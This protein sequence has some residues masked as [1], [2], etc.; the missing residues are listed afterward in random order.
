[1]KRIYFIFAILAFSFFDASAQTRDEGIAFRNNAIEFLLDNFG[2][3]SAVQL[4][5][6]GTLANGDYTI[7]FWFNARN[8]YRNQKIFDGA[9]GRQ[10]N[11]SSSIISIGITSSGNLIINNNRQPNVSFNNNQ[12]N[13]VAVVKTGTNCIIYFNGVE[14]DR[15]TV[16][17]NSTVISDPIIGGSYN[18]SSYSFLGQCQ[19]FRVWSTARTAQQIQDN[20]RV[21]IPNNSSNL[22]YY[23]PLTQ[24]NIN[25]SQNINDGTA[26]NNVSTA[27]GA[28]SS[29]SN[30]ISN[31][32]AFTR[33][34][35]DNTHQ[36][37]S[38]TLAQPLTDNQIVQYSLDCGNNWTNVDATTGINWVATLPANF[39]SGPINLRIN[40]APN[41]L[42]KDYLVTYNIFEKDSIV[43]YN[44][45]FFQTTTDA[46]GTNG[47]YIQLPN[48]GYLANGD[49]T[50]ETW[51]KVADKNR[52]YQ[53][54]FEAGTGVSNNILSIGFIGTTGQLFI[55]G[56]RAV[57]TV[58][59]INNNQWYHIAM[60]KS[61][62]AI[63]TYLNGVQIDNYSFSN[64]GSNL[65]TCKIG[66]SN[67]NN[68]STI[69][70]FQEFRIW[71]TAKNV[72]EIR[73]N[74][75]TK[76]LRNASNL[77][78]Y[79]PLSRD[80]IV[81]SVNIVNATVLQNASTAA[82]ANQ[83]NAVV[84][85]KN[86]FGARYFHDTSRQ[87]LYGTVYGN[88]PLEY[89]VNN[90]I[91]WTPIDAYLG[92][93]WVTTL[94]S[95]F[96]TGTI[97]VRVPNESCR[98]FKDYT[99][100]ADSFFNT[101]TTRVVNGTISPNKIV[102]LF[103]K[104]QITYSP[105]P[106]YVLDSIFINGVYNAAASSDSLSS[107]T[108]N[109]TFFDSIKVV[110]SNKLRLKTI[111]RVLLKQGDTLI[112]RS[113]P[114]DNITLKKFN[115]N[116]T[117]NYFKKEYFLSNDTNYYFVI[118][119]N[120]PVGTYVL[121]GVNGLNFTTNFFVITIYN[122]DTDSVAIYGWG[123]SDGGQLNV[124]NLRTFV[125][126]AGGEAF[127]AGLQKDGTVLAWGSNANG[128][129][130][131]PATLKDVVQISTGFAHGLAL[132]YDGT[133]EAWGFNNNGQT[134][135]PQLL[136][137]NIVQVEAGEFFSL[138][139]KLDGT[140]IGWG[141]NVPANIN[142]VVQLGAGF[143]NG[144]AITGDS[145]ILSWGD[146]SNGQLTNLPNLRGVVQAK[147]GGSDLSN[148]G[149][150][151][152][153][154]KNDG[155]LVG[156]GINN[157]GQLNMPQNLRNVTQIANG[158][159]HTVALLKDKSV[160]SFGASGYGQLNQPTGI[161]NCQAVFSGCASNFSFAIS[162]L[163]VQSSANNGGRITDTTFV[164]Y[165]DNF[166]VTFTPNVGYIVDSVFINEVYDSIATYDSFAGYTFYNITSNPSIRV[167]FTA[168]TSYN[169]NTT[170]VNGTIDTSR[171][172]GLG[173]NVTIFYQ[174]QIG[175]VIDSVII[176]GV[177]KR[178]D[179]VSSY[180]FT[181]V[182]GDSNLRVVFKI[183]TFKVEAHAGIGGTI[184]PSGTNVA[185]YGSN[186]SFSFTASRDYYID[187]II[188]NSIRILPYSTQY[189][190]VNV[191]GDS[192]IRITF[193]PRIT[194]DS[195][196]KLSNNSFQTSTNATGSNGDYIILPNLGDLANG[197]FTIETWFKISDIN[198]NYQRI[199]EAGT[200][201]NNNII[202]IG[203]LGTSGQLFINSNRAIG[204]TNSINNNQ[205]Y[206]IAMVKKSTIIT[207]YLNGVQID[208]YTF[209][210]NT[211][212]LSTC[213][214][215][216][217][218]YNDN[219]TLG[220]FQEFRIWKTS[221]SA[222]DIN[223]FYRMSPLNN[224]PN[225]Y[226][227]L[228]LYRNR[229][230]QVANINNNTI[231][232]NAAS[233]VGANNSF[234]TIISN[235]S[236]RGA[237]YFYEKN[238]QLLYGTLYDSLLGN[239][240]LQYSVDSG[241]NWFN[242]DTAIGY[243]WV[244]TL[245]ANFTSGR[246]KV[247]I[248][249]NP[250]RLFNDYIFSIDTL[251][252]STITTIAVN[253]SI[254]PLQ[255]VLTGDNVQI[256]Y[257]PNSGYVLDSIYINGVYNRRASYD[258]INSFTLTNV[259]NDT[260][261]VV[262][263]KKSKLKQLNRGLFKPGDTLIL[264]SQLLQ[265][266]TIKKFNSSYQLFPLK[267]EAIFTYDTNYYFKLPYNLTAGNYALLGIN[268]FS[269]SE[270][271][272]VIAV[273]NFDTD[274]VNNFKWGQNNNGQL[275]A[276][277]LQTFVQFSGGDA[278]T[279]GLQK[280]GTVLAWGSNTRG[281]L[282]VPTDLK[283]VVQISTGFGH[284]LALKYDGTV[285]G[286]GYNNNTQATVPTDLENV[287]QVEAGAFHSVALKYDG[288]VR[289]WGLNNYNQINVPSNI[290]SIVLLGA[291]YYHTLALKLDSTVEA[292][293]GN[294]DGQTTIPPGLKGVIQVKAGGSL[295]SN[296]GGYSMVLK[297][298]GTLQGWGVN[299]LGQLNIP[300]N[301]RNVIQ[302]AN[303]ENHTVALVNAGTLVPF[304]ASSSQQLNVPSQFKNVVAVFSG[305]ASNFSYAISKLSVQ[306]I[307]SLNGTIA[308]T[309]F[310]KYNDKFRVTYAPNIGYEVD[311][312]FIDG[313][314]SASAS[315]DSI[316][317]F[318]FYGITAN[319]TIRVSFKSQTFNISTIFNT[320]GNVTVVGSNSV[321][322]DSNAQVS[323]SAQT[324]YFI[325]SIFKNSNLYY[326]FNSG[327]RTIGDTFKTLNLLHV[328]GDSVIRVSFKRS[329]IS[330]AP[331]IDS[332]I[333]NNTQAT[334]FYTSPL[335]FGGVPILYY[336]IY[337]TTNNITTVSTST[338]MPIV[339]QNLVNHNSYTFKISAVNVNGESVMS[340]IS[341]TVVPYNPFEKDSVIAYFNNSFQ[342][343]TLGLSA[344][345]DYV[346]LPT[347]DLSN[348]FTIETWFKSNI[349]VGNWERIF[350]FGQNN[351][352]VGTSEGVLLG[353]PTSTQFGYHVNGSDIITSF[354]SNFNPQNWNHYAL[355]WNGTAVN[356]YINGVLVS[357]VTLGQNNIMSNTCVSNFI[358]RSNWNDSSTQGLFNSFRIWKSARSA[359]EV[360]QNYK[361]KILTNTTNLYYY[362][363]LNQNNLVKTT[364]ISNNTILNNASTAL[365]ALMASATIVSQNSSGA[366]YFYDSSRQQLFGSLYLPL[367]PNEII[368]YSVNNGKT[369]LNVDTVSGYSWVATLPLGFKAGTIKVRSYLNPNR[370]FNDYVVMIAPQN[371]AYFPNI[372][373]DTFTTS[374]T[375]GLPYLEAG[376]E[377]NFRIINGQ[378][379]GINI[380]TNTGRIQWTNS[381]ALGTY[382]LTV[383][384]SNALGTDTTQVTL[385]ISKA[386]VENSF[387]YPS[388]GI[389]GTY[390]VP[391]SSVMPIISNP[392]QQRF[393]SISPSNNGVGINSYTGK[394][395]WTATTPAQFNVYTI[396]ADFGDS[397]A[398]RQVNFYLNYP[399]LNFAYTGNRQTYIVPENVYLMYVDLIGATGGCV[400]T[401]YS[402]Y[403]S[404]G[405]R[406][407][408]YIKVTP[409]DTLSL[410]IGGS[411]M[412]NTAYGG[413]KAGGYNGGG[414]TTTT[415]SGSNYPA[416]QSGS[417]GGATD[418]RR[419]G[420]GL[421]NRIVV[422]G[423]GS[424]Q[425]AIY[426][427]G[428]GGGL[429]GAGGGG[430]AG[431]GTQTMGGHAGDYV[432]GGATN[433][434]F[435]YGGTGT[436]DG[437]GGGGGW[438]GGGG[439][440]RYTGGGGSNYAIPGAFN[441]IHDQGVNG[442][443]GYSYQTNDPQSHTPMYAYVNFAANGSLSL[444]GFVY[445]PPRFFYTDSVVSVNNL[446]S[447]QSVTPIANQAGLIYKMTN[448]INGI[449]IDSNTGIIYW[450][451][452]LSSNIY[453]LQ[454]KANSI[455]NDS[456]LAKFILVVTSTNTD[457]I[458][459]FKNAN[460]KLSTNANG[461]GGDYIMLPN[462]DL[463][464]SN[465]TIETWFK[466]E[467][468]IG[469][470][471]R[472]FDFGQKSGANGTNSGVLLAFANSTQ[473]YFHSN[474]SE[475][476]VVD[477]PANFISTNWNHFA[478]SLQ[479]NNLN[480]YLNGV[481]I[482]SRNYNQYSLS[483]NALVSNFIGRSNWD[484]D[485]TTV[486]QF[487]DFRVWKRA[488][489]TDDIN[490]IYKTYSPLDF[491]ALYYY[492]PLDTT[493]SNN[494]P[495]PNNTQIYN[496]ANT[497]LQLNSP[498]TIISKNNTG[499]SFS[500]NFA[501]QTLKGS[502]A[503]Q[504]LP[505]E[506]IQYSTDTGKTW[507]AVDTNFLYN[508]KA[509]LPN[510]FYGG[511]IKVRTSINN[512]ATLR[513]FND[514]IVRF[515]PMIP[516]IDSVVG[517]NSQ[518][519]VYFTPN[520]ATLYPA[521]SG[522]T[523]TGSKPNIVNFGTTSPVYISGL[524]NDSPYTFTM[525]ATNII[526]TSAASN[527]SAVVR[528]TNTF[529][530][531]ITEVVNGTIS[532][533]RSVHAGTKYRITYNPISFAYTLDS[534]YINGV[535]NVID[536][537]DSITGYTFDTI[538]TNKS[539][540]VIYKLKSF[541]ITTTNNNG[542]NIHFGSGTN[543][544]NYGGG[545]TL[546]IA[547]NAGFY[548]DS[549]F[550]N[551]ALRLSF[552]GGQQIGDTLYN[553]TLENIT[554]DSFV[555][556][557]FK[558]STISSAPSIDTVIAGNTIATIYAS[559]PN[560]FGGTR[561][562]FY[563]IASY[564]NAG[565]RVDTVFSFP[566][567]LQGLTND[568][569]YI[570][571]IQAVNSNGLSPWSALS[572]GIVPDPDLYNI[573]TNV[574]NGT[575][576]DA[577]DNITGID[578][579]VS[580]L[581]SGD[582]VNFVYKPLLG[583][584]LDSVVVDSV[585]VDILL[586]PDSFKF[587][588]IMR[589]H[590]IAV[591]Y[592]IIQ[593]SVR[594]T[595]GNNGSIS[596]SLDTLLDY[597]ASL[598][599]YIV[600]NYG[601]KIDSLFIN[602]IYIENATNLY[603][604]NNIKTNINLRVSFILKTYIINASSGYGGSITPSGEDTFDFGS[605]P[606]YMFIP[607]AGFDIDSIFVN[608]I[609]VN[610]AMSYT[611]DSVKSN[612]TIRVAFKMQ[613]F[614]ITSS[615]G[616]NGTI[617]PSGSQTFVY[618][619]RPIFTFHPNIGYEI[620]SVFVNNNFV[621]SNDSFMFDSVKTN[622]TIYVKYKE[623]KFVITTRAT[624][625][626]LAIIQGDTVV[627]YGANTVL[628]ITPNQGY[629]IRSISINNNLINFIDSNID[630]PYHYKLLNITENLN[631]VVS[632]RL[633]TFAIFAENNMGGTLNP[634]GVVL[635]D[636]NGS[637]SF[638]FN[639]DRG[640]LLDSVLI[641]G[642]RN[643]DSTN[644]FT[645][646]S[647]TS[648]QSLKIVYKQQN[649]IISSRARI[650]GSI[651]PAGETM[652]KFDSNITYQI[653]PNLGFLVDSVF[654]NDTFATTD[655]Y[656][657]FD[658]VRSN[659]NIYAT[660]KN[661]TYTITTTAGNGGSI[662]PQ[663]DTLIKFD[664]SIRYVFN[665]NTGYEV[666]SVFVNNTL[667]TTA[668]S[669]TFNNVMAD[670]SLRVTFKIKTYTINASAGSGGS[671][672]PSGISTVNYGSNLTFNISAN[673]GY[674]LDSLWVNNSLIN[675]VLQYTFTNITANQSIKVVFKRVVFH[676]NF[677]F[678]D[679]GNIRFEDDT[680]AVFDGD[681]KSILIKALDTFIIDSI[682]I[683]GQVVYRFM[684]GQHAGIDS[685]AY[686]FMDVLGDSNIYVS[687]KKIQASTAPILL[688][689]IEGNGQVVIRFDPPNEWNGAK[690]VKYIVKSVNNNIEVTGTESPIVVSNL[691]NN[692]LYKFSIA[693]ENEWGMVSQY[694]DTTNYVIPQNNLININTNVVNG[695]ISNAT[696]IPINGSI[697]ITYKPF[698]GYELD[699]III[700]DNF[701]GRD[702]LS[703]YT[704]ENLTTNTTIKVVFKVKTFTITALPTQNGSITPMGLT[705]VSF[706]KNILYTIVANAGYEIDS[707]LIDGISLSK[708]TQ[709]LFT[710]VVSNRTIYASFKIK[711]FKIF[712][713]F[714]ANGSVSP[715]GNLLINYGALQSFK[716]YPNKYYVVDSVF[717]NGIYNSDSI[718]GYTF[719]NVRGDSN[720]RVTFK[721]KQLSNQV[722]SLVLT[723]PNC[724]GN[725]GQATLNFSDTTLYNKI[726]VRNT[727]S[728]AS[729]TY[730]LS[731]QVFVVNGLQA[732][733]IYEF[734]LYDSTP[735]SLIPIRLFNFTLSQPQQLST[736]SQV[737][738][739]SKLLTLN[740]SGSNNYTVHINGK[741]YQTKENTIDLPLL[742]GVNK[743]VVKTE[744]ACQGVYEETILV[745]ETMSL[746]PNPTTN[747]VTLNVGGSDTKLQVSLITEQGK[748]L[749]TKLVELDSYR[750]VV[751]DVSA[752]P[753]GLYVL[754]VSGANV[755]GTLKLIKQ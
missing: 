72:N 445:Q 416:L 494:T 154:L 703:S 99:Y 178:I 22:L 18:L 283:D 693:A 504:L 520:P 112:L 49:F 474:S 533:K 1:M 463:A 382:N 24:S 115:S 343:T 446:I 4:P 425:G 194:N 224:S 314:Y 349:R 145:T 32:D 393:Y 65:S 292:W 79:L 269:N 218:N 241:T 623:Q 401:L 742:I 110:F 14:V 390:G 306:T 547:A 231:L 565:N 597:N 567:T 125:Q 606:T 388:V 368:Q 629:S 709:F 219:S 207:T 342:T 43:A 556:V 30:V 272:F 679:G 305:C 369:Y 668:N 367:Q 617:D 284:G 518:V 460:I 624:N 646:N 225:L 501:E 232:L 631:I 205:W 509:T 687:F 702:S 724:Y 137:N 670:Q 5:S 535:Y 373:Y 529:D 33:Y 31:L 571:R 148:Y 50:I 589:N 250:N 319:H 406:V 264:R 259:H 561:I 704:L 197:D 258:S 303:G 325:D 157:F 252:A 377:L 359:Q 131:V 473:M 699:S 257:S 648:N 700:N 572:H 592:S 611:F 735:N 647:V 694:S 358:G 524:T 641:N 682:L 134:T 180:T 107:Y 323:I 564:S 579:V 344:S 201:P 102:P 472:I 202:S 188:I 455:R 251:D 199:F 176:N 172:V 173:R 227:Y 454:I 666:D 295:F 423:G 465:Y 350:D 9:N 357:S 127:A 217:S 521:I 622:Q 712:A 282:N 146:N 477:L 356:L 235:N 603:Q 461:S 744:N 428:Q 626:G 543:L 554:G 539:I 10:Y 721:L 612:Q 655:N 2:H 439:G 8:I 274:S 298:N 336:N 558:Q 226:Y 615:A 290:D 415:S 636:Y 432:Y 411:G 560:N 495:I 643:L 381:L 267:K 587:V 672:T 414:S 753:A 276:P 552:R 544:V 42:F 104:T 644:S 192:T 353:F 450:N 109:F 383:V 568:S 737:E 634:N 74:Y 291:G 132:K 736:L 513:V 100:V 468:T 656:Y 671:I 302:I 117:L 431:G 80:R 424:G 517:L 66:A 236:G 604:I 625:G 220:Q 347:L 70:Q 731:G 54:I 658:S 490:A 150:Y 751:L 536:S 640:Y 484:V 722:V 546:I 304:G 475:Y 216:A 430:N 386:A 230:A 505:N 618:G 321:K 130:N 338:N 689:A 433:G 320:G 352:G 442:G 190:F 92:N 121:R 651:N 584:K 170:V 480:L 186:I 339:I 296:V 676:I 55:N 378:S 482:A 523:V 538:T 717:V 681:D 657:R 63:T 179:Y 628:T 747:Q 403:N 288:R 365:G 441:V 239:E 182:R 438:Y 318:T 650:G 362:L 397:F 341:N 434:G 489:S 398:V 678:N 337:T 27:A 481:L 732:D 725:S 601:Y 444:Q 748:Y 233:A 392:N 143:Y 457:S 189:T 289:A 183:K 36:L 459:K 404:G 17:N 116:I 29:T 345:G 686:T 244:A 665:P 363:P 720:I 566:A 478:L 322:Y 379:A 58:N 181:N 78:Y 327:G 559:K 595:V 312:I 133:V 563:R 266:I 541:T 549:I 106:G 417:G 240:K 333:A 409:G 705:Q 639:A 621:T 585:K 16:S 573:I 6:I 738:S 168:T 522:Y 162:K 400:S 245:P 12:W 698:V 493:L 89:S 256:T 413:P 361:T 204:S 95:S 139:L 159:N 402:Q 715:S 329:S 443:Q 581:L 88:K 161:K 21:T 25:S 486:G 680:H 515:P 692:F 91:S 273:F 632:F 28:I 141:T 729:I 126:L 98:L 120:L 158:E 208:N 97:K 87:L 287:I 696:S 620:D 422:A 263:S 238:R 590:S 270:N 340:A 156:N 346:Q 649:F 39:Y 635:V 527:I 294:G 600:P 297:Q 211:A 53:R 371:F 755:Q 674:E 510:N 608:N 23:L 594:S 200:S 614:T 507:Q 395:F 59:T 448:P 51:F 619:A 456:F 293:G 387:R 399:I 262:F 75:K 553:I 695:T 46:T 243:Y 578:Y 138:A 123:Q 105:N 206:H 642:V 34:T 278:F 41:R 574:V 60:V 214:L 429:I 174:P 437:G 508:W 528:P 355:V 185:N 166:R 48:L 588:N 534:I 67:Y 593:Y 260:I 221:K 317:G 255:K 242:I 82:G 440:D 163:S 330:S 313:V 94:P 210:N 734:K 385:K 316:Q 209:G 713:S 332:V 469:N 35:F 310:V 752:Y 396:T 285:V 719:N 184:S 136:N 512:V 586:Y 576:T 334:I 683:N 421:N 248:N 638:A 410:F 630:T 351:N 222:Q 743:I 203:F 591:Y 328:T 151:T 659:Q 56:S 690:I 562:L 499:A 519:L 76:I 85:S 307:R 557:V 548:I 261:K 171:K 500:V 40:N 550:V 114:I 598:P 502:I 645:F 609:L 308:D 503:N 149:G 81:Q 119:N 164:K 511:L 514:F 84:I 555:N 366:R 277:N 498:A 69:G 38:G 497:S 191:L 652:V 466:N 52:D 229:I 195:I 662:S 726:E 467:G 464:N 389:V 728:N 750:N 716:F 531:I 169:I 246:I 419:G 354:P 254:S 286:W 249:N 471:N 675:N 452:T 370:K 575:I 62:G 83:G 247:R 479:G 64:N 551:N 537:R 153:V 331:G 73:Q 733:S 718:S 26:L 348:N 7:E 281:E 374:G 669:Y 111:N 492:L 599:I 485:R 427:G 160:V 380:D 196:L 372:I 516:R 540:R 488:L 44:N 279:A 476:V 580:H 215:G 213:K 93:Y 418:I 315:A 11:T 20:Y 253:G 128:E 275:N 96:V 175:Y 627:S 394:L 152:M 311:S 187:S 103:E 453:N 663:G 570:F 280:N 376:G 458:V 708:S 412:N 697:T 71:T 108:F 37:L 15:Y 101:I 684:N 384:V 496:Q 610:N 749:F 607:N 707:L 577:K 741:M 13:H 3:A 664:S 714:G 140:V 483:P 582:S 268:E 90:G 155:T 487:R 660:F 730:K 506:H 435:G 405:G 654:V 754:K 360:Q 144:L 637:Q 688:D 165:H 57:G 449:S 673:K 447:G 124:P 605:R 739:G 45:N 228:P 710:N 653:T 616:N 706:G 532:P 602:D 530:I 613:R 746:Y 727:I 324:G 271:V 47:D 691:T 68:A 335:N 309:T 265:K 596:I 701:V 326:A 526:T 633:K 462:L 525:T 237:K 470:S 661:I 177:N 212:I 61:G 77:Y 436:I 122:F 142:N 167:K 583:Y 375:T 740:L 569:S 135:I 545:S 118:P 685:F 129:L 667:V 300:N 723:S 677:S 408:A 198:R 711:T 234:S 223:R 299:N 420:I 407:R 113:Q 147:A 745:S 491:N 19:E 542:G 451:H 86:N 426:F 301:L 364:N 193:K 391:D